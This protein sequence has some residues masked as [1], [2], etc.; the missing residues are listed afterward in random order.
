MSMMSKRKGEREAAGELRRVFGVEAGRGVQYSGGMDSPD[1]VGLAGVHLEVKR[2]EKLSLHGA[3]T[4]AIDD[5]GDQTPMV[6]HRPNRASWMATVLLADLP[7]L[8]AALAPLLTCGRCHHWQAITGAPMGHCTVDAMM[9][10]TG[11]RATCERWI[12]PLKGTS[13]G[14][15]RLPNQATL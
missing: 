6:L 8:V 7:R 9:R 14:S 1:V 2:C 11:G 3:M 10:M 15:N 5:A 4:Q 13:G 12:P